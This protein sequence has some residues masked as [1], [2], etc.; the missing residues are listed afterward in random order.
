MS[1]VPIFAPD[2]TLGDIPQ[3]Q[4]ATAV[5]AGAKPGVHIT[6]PDGSPGV[7]PADRVPDAANAGAKVVPFE[8][9]PAKSFWGET[10]KAIWSDIKSIPNALMSPDP[11]ADP[12]VSDADKWNIYQKQSA[13]AQATN[14]QRVKEHGQAYSLGA[15]ANEMMGINVAGEE[16][17]AKEGNPGAVVGHALTVPLMAGAT[18]GLI[19]GAPAVGDAATKVGQAAKV[20]GQV[21]KDVATPE[22]IA[23]AVGS[24]VGGYAGHLIGEPVGLGIAGGAVGR[25][26]GKSV[27]KRL[28]STPEAVPATP[29]P[30]L[31]QGNAL[32]E[33]GKPISS[34][35][36][37]LSSLPA[38]AKA[39]KPVTEAPSSP[40]AGQT[41]SP[42]G[43][44][45]QTVQGTPKSLF[46]LPIPAVQQAIK[47]LGTSAPLPSLTARANQIA[48]LAVEGAGSVEK[49][50]LT[51]PLKP[52]VPLKNQITPARR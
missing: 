12:R 45:P 20:T 40:V 33:G 1:T 43:V 28:A 32:T 39:P 13:A 9:Q 49:L 41:A 34:P 16:Q 30:E 36:D 3:E 22:N 31:L 25:V 10:A 19:K 51:E 8:D 15:S 47:E 11:L 17:G 50:R 5:K 48:N 6:G 14:A 46:D 26:I 23:T 24:G 37:A 27:A 38:T 52:N 44:T 18:E 2:G 29:A 42:K 21:L 35:S 7:I 4:L